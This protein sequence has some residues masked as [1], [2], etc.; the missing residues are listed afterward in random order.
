[1]TS[2]VVRPL[3][4]SDDSAMASIIETVMISLGMPHGMG[5]SID[6]DEVTV[7]F[8]CHCRLSGALYQLQEVQ[9]ISG[10]SATVSVA[11]ITA[12]IILN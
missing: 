7:V 10:V 4:K 3:V 2:F 5:Y 8:A 1:M 6:D 12:S 9:C 11:G